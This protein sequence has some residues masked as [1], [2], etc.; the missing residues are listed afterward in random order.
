MRFI[1]IKKFYKNATITHSDVPNWFEINLDKRKLK[2]PNG[3]IFKVPNE[4]LALAVATEWNA[5][6][7]IIKR[8][9][10]HL[11]ALCN[12]AIDNPTH[13]SREDVVRNILHFIETD[14]LC[15]RMA[16][17]EELAKYQLKCWEP[18]VQWARKRYEIEIESTTGLA[19][20]DVPAETYEKLRAYL[21][22]FS[23]WALIGF[24]Y[25]TETMKSLI[26]ML[27]LV[28]K[29][30]NV[31][32]AVQLSRLEQDYQVL[33][34]GN[35]EWYHDLDIQELKARIA[36]ATLFIYWTSES[37]VTKKKASTSYLNNM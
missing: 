27:A 4:A 37:S 1:E 2:T 21:L 12:T 28:A 22:T 29:Q 5:Q 31:E 9:Y 26:L 15:Y 19:S 7:K 30:I 33:K 16:E 34:W 25:G 18:V 14:T 13:R 6:D 23:D 32:T 24:L 20:P 17:P 11:T 3:S 8:N 36:A 10:M 35:V